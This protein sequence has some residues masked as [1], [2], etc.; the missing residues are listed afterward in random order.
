MKLPIIND[1]HFGVKGDSKIFREYMNTFFQN[2]FFPYLDQHEFKEIVH[3]G[4]VF[5]NR[6]QI[7]VETMAFFSKNFF[8]PLKERGIKIHILIG[9]HDAYFKNTNDVNSIRE[10]LSHYDNVVMY[11]SP[12]DVEFDGTN[13][14]MVPWLNPENLADFSSFLT[15]TNSRSLM[16]HFEI[17]GFEVMRGT[18]SLSG[19]APSV[20]ADFDSIYSGHF[21]QKSD[22]GKIF[23]LGT[24]FDMSFA[25][26]N[27]TKG[28]HVLDTSTG[29]LEFI[30]NQDKMFY[31]LVYDDANLPVKYQ[32]PDFSK[33][34]NRFV[35]LIVKHKKNANLL[36][37]YLSKLYAVSPYEVSI[38]DEEELNVVVSDKDIDITQDTMSIIFQDIEDNA[39]IINKEK[40]KTIMHE[41]YVESFEVE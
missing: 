26:L 1:T 27:E 10:F 37:D 18:A 9:N 2:V 41:L 14:G 33:Y 25:D 12:I 40:L 32:H 30:A 17:Q 29:K 38:I 28:F 34:K 36:E 31:K 3:L 39:N 13:I 16:G 8:L 15:K 22:D 6:K 11:D 21:H 24:Q 20:F 23:Y 19:L 35:K 7:N 5:D 4:D